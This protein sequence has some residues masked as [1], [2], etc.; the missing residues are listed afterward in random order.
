ML[1]SD[2]R[3]L[4]VIANISAKND[5]LTKCPFI[6]L[7]FNNSNSLFNVCLRPSSF[8][9]HS[10]NHLKKLKNGRPLVSWANRF[11]LLSLFDGD[12]SAK[13]LVHVFPYRLDIG[14]F[15][16]QVHQLCYSGFYRTVIPA[17]D[18]CLF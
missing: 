3:L 16:L 17:D 4:I 5:K 18:T 12:F 6:F 15:A 14:V 10:F 1:N 8:F 11:L 13:A 2:I 7:L 9:L